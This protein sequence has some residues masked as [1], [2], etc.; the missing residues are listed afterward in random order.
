MEKDGESSY[1]GDQPGSDS[2]TAAPSSLSQATGATAWAV[3]ADRTFQSGVSDRKTVSQALMYHFSAME[4]IAAK[5]STTTPTEGEED[6]K[7]TGQPMT[8]DEAE[9][10]LHAAGQVPL[11]GKEFHRYEAHGVWHYRIYHR[12]SPTTL[13]GLLTWRISPEFLM[14]DVKKEC[15]KFPEQLGDVAELTCVWHHLKGMQDGDWTTWDSF[16]EFHEKYFPEPVVAKHQS[17]DESSG[18]EST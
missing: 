18:D 17:D 4:T 6:Q 7:V 5:C 11:Q 13:V 15:E 8:L 12:S 10:L 14:Q 9:R 2:S 1:E 3:S 16:E